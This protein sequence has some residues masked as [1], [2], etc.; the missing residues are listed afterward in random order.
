MNAHRKVQWVWRVI[1]RL[2]ILFTISITGFSQP[3]QS[4]AQGTPVDDNFLYLPLVWKPC[5]TPEPIAN[6][7]FES[8]STYWTEGGPY[9]TPGSI[10]RHDTAQLGV[11]PHS[12]NWAAWLHA[13]FTPDPMQPRSG[14]IER[15]ISVPECSPH[16]EYWYWALSL[17]MW[18]PPCRIEASVIVNGESLYTHF[19]VYNSTH[20]EQNHINLED[21]AGQTVTLQFRIG[22]NSHEMP[23]LIID[24][25]G[26]KPGP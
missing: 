15:V 20:W 23:T 2:F 26:F 18:C 4:H 6:G 16:L 25:V 8:G 11:P 5:P 10:I 9:V 13:G 19:M 1:G 14:Y 12:G 24:D 3:S 22:G 17:G 21:Y 7:D